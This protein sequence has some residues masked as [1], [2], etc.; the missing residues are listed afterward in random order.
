MSCGR[1]LIVALA[2]CGVLLPAVSRGL[3]AA[4]SEAQAEPE[5]GWSNVTDL[6]L[7]VTDGNSETE[8]FH[9]HSLLEWHSLRAGFRL[10]LDGLRSNTADDRYRQVDPGFVWEPGGQPPSEVTTTL[11]DP[12]K[13]PDVE[14]YFIEARYEQSISSKPRLRP[15][16]M[17]WHV[18]TTWDRNLDAGILSRLV[19]YAGLG[20]VWWDQEDL[21]FRTIYSLSWTDR[22]EET[23]DP[24]KDDQFP[25]LR[26]NWVYENRWGKN[27]VFHHEW[28]FNTNLSELSD[29]SS[30]MTSSLRIP[31]TERLSLRVSLHWLYNNLPALEDVDL[32]ARVEVVD[33]DGIP[34]N[35]DEYFETVESGGFPIDAGSVLER[36]E[37]L[38]TVFT[39]S[40]GIS[41]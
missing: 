34:G 24:E 17:S 10:K 37:K 5:T 22:S 9:L 14:K 18:G 35:G 38:D 13:E 25:G 8:G 12:D 30:E 20:H 11:V 21:K 4:E 36:K 40:L 19:V 26:Y 7:T 23:Q 1:G 16:T 27:V 41:F 2:C 32:V 15:G 28:T 3:P 6:G 39:T 29:F 33:P 31:M